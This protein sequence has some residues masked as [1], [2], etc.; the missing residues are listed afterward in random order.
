M[1][2]LWSFLVISRKQHFLHS[3]TPFCTEM[4]KIAKK[5]HS[6]LF[7][8]YQESCFSSFLN[9]ELII[10]DV[11][12]KSP[13]AKNFRHYSKTEIK[14]C[15]WHS[16][17]SWLFELKQ[18]ILKYGWIKF[19]ELYNIFVL[20]LRF[21]IN[22]KF[23]IVLI[24]IYLKSGKTKQNTSTIKFCCLKMKTSLKKIEKWTE[25]FIILYLLRISK[26]IQ[27]Y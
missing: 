4:P 20:N 22:R 27:M 7:H 5:R 21:H 23:K 8:L 14:S 6:F 24:S 18:T 11:T 17:S 13:V 3:K 16:N 19:T 25:Y 26:E 1:S 2:W 12:Q 10:S 9:F 15:S